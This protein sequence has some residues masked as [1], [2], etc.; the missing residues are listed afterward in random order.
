M[1]TKILLILTAISFLFIFFIFYEGLNRSN[2]YRPDIVTNKK[3]PLFKVKVFET[4]DE[5]ISKKIFENDIYYVFNIWASWCIP[6]RDEH[7][8]LMEL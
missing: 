3:I 1:K 6:C 2:I 5:I 7:P 4:D 8:F